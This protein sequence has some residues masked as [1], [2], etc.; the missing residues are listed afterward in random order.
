MTR[1]PRCQAENPLGAAACLTCGTRLMSW[2]TLLMTP[3]QLAA[4]RP[5]VTIRVV[6]AD[7]GPEVAFALKKDEATAGS[8]GDILLM[9]DPFVARHQARFSFVGCALMVEVLSGGSGVY[10]R[11]KGDLL[12]H[13]GDELR[14]GRQR[15]LIEPMPP[16]ATATPRAW[17]APAGGARLRVVQVLEGGLRGE[18]WPLRDGE[19]LL[20]REIG[21]ITFVGDGFVSGRHALLLAQ[22]EHVTVRDLGSSNGTFARLAATT[23]LASGDQLLIGRQLL[24]VELA[25]AA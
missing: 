9:D 10:G 18:A 7:G 17:G 20:G 2:G 15:L 23:L 13:A 25:D 6:R 1:G 14:C 3:Q 5:R 11:L 8:A 12:M 22:G 21:D 4:E 16:L 24:K 19:N